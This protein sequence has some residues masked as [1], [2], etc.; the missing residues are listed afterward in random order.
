MIEERIRLARKSAGMSLRAT[1][2]ATGLSATAISK[3]ETGQLT[4]SS[5]RLLSLAQAFGVR[6]EY[7]FRPRTLELT[8]VEYRKRS[9]LGKKVLDRIEGNV[10]E[11]VERLVELLDIFPQ[12]PLPDFELPG[13]LPARIDTLAGV[14]T[15][16]DKLR[17]AWE[18]GFDPI[19]DLT[20]VLEER[21]L[22]VLHCEVPSD[23]RFD[24]LACRVDGFRVVVVGAD[25]PG[26]RQRFA[27]A[28]ELGHLMVAGR[29]GPGLSEEKACNRFAGS[30]L[31]P[32]A[33]VRAA[34][35]ERR[36]RIEPRELLVLKQELG[37]SMQAILYRAKDLAILNPS[38]FERA[39]KQFSAR[40]WRS[41]EP[42]E[43]IP[44]EQ[45][46]FFEQLV[47][48]ALAEDQIGE[49]KAAELLGLPLIRF[50]EERRLEPTL[51]AAHQ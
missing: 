13:A 9:S 19:A 1:A 24:G 12:R 31:A 32:A 14:E 8:R 41:Q 36:H 28:H 43:P 15:L 7:F 21:G 29:L 34:L 40:G 20:S 26:D 4:P 27:L 45:P 10:V 49:S 5:D 18:L 6:V 48:R 16:T 3:Y 17:L 33:T 47:Y 11:Q 51:A 30:F 37:M 23:G 2:G 22:V 44:P 25:W 39:M 50:R 38:A 46:R 35:G 42:G